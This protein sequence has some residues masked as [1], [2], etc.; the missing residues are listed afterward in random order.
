MTGNFN[1][2]AR[3]GMEELVL[4]GYY[5]LVEAGAE[6]PIT[7]GVR[8]KEKAPGASPLQPYR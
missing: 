2:I 4:S 7:Y 6:M 3:K 5:T 1:L 8:L